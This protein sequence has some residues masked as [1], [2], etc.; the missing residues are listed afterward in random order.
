MKVFFEV[1]CLAVKPHKFIGDDGEDVAYNEITFL[2][3]T[4]DG[5]EVITLNSKQ[6]E[7]LW[8]DKDGV[9]AVEIDPTGK[10]KPRLLEFKV[11]A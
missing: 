5:R 4:D 10:K 8:V 9:I 6:G 11:K 3:V 2:N 7:P 1:S